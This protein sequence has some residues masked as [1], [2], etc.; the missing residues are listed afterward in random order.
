M[1]GSRGYE[2]LLA[3][4]YNEHCPT[5]NGDRV[6]F[7][8]SSLTFLSLSRV[9]K[10]NS[11]VSFLGAVGQLKSSSLERDPGAGE[12]AQLVK[13]LAC[14]NED[15]FALQSSC[16]EVGHGGL[17]LESQCWSGENRQIPGASRPG[18]LPVWRVQ[19]QRATLSRRHSS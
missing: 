18:R 10:S 4:D 16:K 2:S 3:W 19:D 6:G 13:C 7:S 17:C 12:R 9:Q 15:L 11:F 14:K 5:L 1:L 8:F